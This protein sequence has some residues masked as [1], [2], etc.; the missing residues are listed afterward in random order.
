MNDKA[1]NVL[2]WVI[3]VVFTLSL[4]IY[5]RATGPTYPLKGTLTVG[6]EEVKFKLLRSHDTGI[7]A[8][9][10]LE[11][12]DPTVAGILEYKRYKSHDK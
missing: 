6:A 7:D 9:V 10:K 2:Y 8:P 5:Q 4:V 3:A 11:L 1:K 12:A